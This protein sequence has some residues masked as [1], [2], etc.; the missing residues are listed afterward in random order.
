MKT[1][2]SIIAGLKVIQTVGNPDVE[3]RELCID[4]RTVT[5]GSLFAALKG[6]QSDGHQYIAD[7]VSKG[8]GAI[9]CEQL[10]E[11]THTEVTYVVVP[12][13]THALGLM[14]AAF[15]DH[16]SRHL[17]LVGVTGTNGKTTTAT[18]LYKMFQEMGCKCGLISTVINYIDQ[19]EIP[20]THTTPDAVSLQQLLAEMV[21]QGCSHCFMEVSS[22]SIVQ[23]RITGL[24]FSGGIFSNLTQ[25]H[26]DFHKTFP[27]YLKAKKIFFDNLPA[28]AFAL[29][30]KDDR[31]GIVMV[32]N[33]RAR[34]HTYALH[35]MADFRAKVLEKHLGG[36]QLTINDREVWV[37]FIGDFNAYNLL[38]VYGAA[39]LLGKEKDDIL[40][41]LSTLTPVAGRFQYITSQ[42]GVTAVIDYAHTPDAV[43][44]VLK[45]IHQITPGTRRAIITVIGCGGDRDKT[46]RP[47]MA[48]IAAKGSSTLI[49]TSDNPRSEHPEDILNDMQAG[50]NEKDLKMTLRISDRHAAI[51]T[52]CM[53]AKTGDMILI[54]GKGHENYQIVKG[55]KS[56]FDDMEEAEK[57]LRERI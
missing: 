17:T 50:L 38:A 16:P 32:Q 52:A 9:L 1:L 49:L 34:V 46:K 27:E 24:H 11:K 33:T 12:D 14:S 26:L 40:R 45:A 57:G 7:T 42:D 36:M 44:N 30:N 35:S 41:V 29:V 48:K 8:V 56:H 22:H 20:A 23:E 10:P 37:R 31:N 54:A 43:E 39:I 5:P 55:V 2:K 3:I 4:S 21:A 13:T 53:M 51:K 47:K 25:D 28:K 19:K 15:Y 6:T 18:L